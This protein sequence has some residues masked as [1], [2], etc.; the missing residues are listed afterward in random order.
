MDEKRK[1]I[2]DAYNEAFHIA[3]EL[4]MAL[5]KLRSIDIDEPENDEQKTMALQLAQEKDM[6]SAYILRYLLVQHGNLVFF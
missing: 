5:V 3:E 1:E 6:R 2:L 4:G